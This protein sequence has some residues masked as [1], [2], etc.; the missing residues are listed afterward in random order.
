MKKKLFFVATI[1]AIVCAL[2]LPSAAAYILSY[3]LGDYGQKMYIVGDAATT[4]PVAD[5]KI[6]A[7]EYTKCFHFTPETEGMQNHLTD[8]TALAEYVDIYASY[9]ENTIY[10]GAVVREDEYTNRGAAASDPYSRIT[11]NLGFNMSGSS[12][13]AADRFDMT[14]SIKDADKKDFFAGLGYLKFNSTGKF[15]KSWAY[16]NTALTAKYY[17]RGTDANGKAITTYEIALSKDEVCNA[18]GLER[19][20]LSNTAFFY[21]EQYP[22]VN[23]ANVG[24]LRYNHLL[25]QEEIIALTDEYGWAPNF[26]GN[27]MVFGNECDLDMTVEQKPNGG[28]EDLPPDDDG[29]DN[30]DGEEDN[31]GADNK[32]TKDTG[33]VTDAPET[34][35][36]AKTEEEK[37]GCKGA[38]ASAGLVC[39]AVA[40]VTSA[41]AV[42]GKRRKED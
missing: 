5:G 1:V 39:L 33:K 10:I 28:G 35:A 14:L 2:T 34:K 17:A 7:N 11:I 38:V 37:K 6:S 19:S 27:L 16:M 25:G 42:I 24:S 15:E 22:T 20:K 3:G 13:G 40:G 32:P 26:L 31:N 18:F 21:F 30:G 4:A 41:V 9:D 8:Q 36:S 23:G 29:E 12:V